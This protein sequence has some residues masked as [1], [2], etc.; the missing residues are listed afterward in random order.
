MAVLAVRSGSDVEPSTHPIVEVTDIQKEYRLG[1]D[2]VVHALRGVS[3]Q[4][5]PGELVA[6]MGPS[7]SGKS[8]FMNLIGCLDRPT[9]GTYL[10]DGADVTHLSRAQLADVRNQ[11]L[12]FIFQGY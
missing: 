12:G 1:H 2:V 3:L 4:V 10:L 8:T 11:K 6:I 7:G 5:N 9:S